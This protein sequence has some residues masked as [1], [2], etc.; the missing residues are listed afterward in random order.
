MSADLITIGLITG[1]TYALL[2]IGLVL[3]YRLQGTLNL[4][5]GEIGAF[6]GAAVAVLALRYGWPF[7]LALPVG[8][9]GGAVLAGL[10][11]IIVI[12][13]LRERSAVIVMVATL[14]VGQLAS[15]LRVSMPSVAPFDPFPTLVD[16][17]MT[18]GPIDLT[19]AE[20]GALLLAPTVALAVWWALSRT[21]AG[22][23]IRA[24]A[25]NPEATRLAGINA[26]AVSTIVWIVAGGLA[27]L[28]TVM[29]VPLRGGTVA[30]IATVG[31]GLLLRGFAAAA[32]GRFR[33]VPLTLAGGLALGVAEAL[34]LTWADDPGTANLIVF[35]IMLVGL[36]VLPRDT[37][38][39][40]ASGA[41]VLRPWADWPNTARV[42]MARYAP[43]VAMVVV[44]VAVPYLVTTAGDT[45]QL[46]RLAILVLV[47]ASASVLSGWSGQVSL[48]QYALAGV[49]AI[50]SARLVESGSTWEVSLLAGTAAAAAVAG[51]V[52]LPSS[53][54]RGS[55][56]A[57]GTLGF[58]VMAP[59]W[60]F[61]LDLTGDNLVFEVPRVDFGL[62]ELRPQRAYYFFVVVI[63][64]IVFALLAAVGRR[65][66]GRRWRAVNDNDRAASAYGISVWRVRVGAFAVSGAIAGLAGGLMGGLLVAYRRGEFAADASV[67]VVVMAVIGGLGS[68][69]GAVFGVLYV[70][71]LPAFFSD[72]GSL[73]LLVSGI[74][75]LVLLL[76]FPDG[77]ARL[78]QRGQRLLAGRPA[79]RAPTELDA[80]DIDDSD[81][82]TLSASIGELSTE[83]A[84]AQPAVGLE[85]SDI[86][87]VFGRLPAVDKVTLAVAPSSI[88][89]LIGPNG[90]GK[91][92]L[93]NVISGLQPATG[94]VVVG[95]TDVSSWSAARRA[96]IGVGRTFQDAR[97]FPTMTVREAVQ[98]AAATNERPNI[99]LDALL[100]R[101][102]RGAEHRI[103]QRADA[104]IELTG[105]GEYA[106]ALIAVLSTG[107]RRMVEIAGLIARAGDLLLFDEPTAGLA[108]REV[109]AFPSVLAAV[110]DHLT[111]TVVVVEH[112]VAMLATACDRL[113]CLEAGRVIA[114]GEPDEVRRDARVI[115][116]YLGPD[117]SAI[118]RSGTRSSN[119]DTRSQ[120]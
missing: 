85:V 22:A 75:L 80:V 119:T 69:A 102:F 62:F 18:I 118:G 116:S 101:A 48:A 115:E 43:A 67:E 10:T 105:L 95:G 13:R 120:P 63:V 93:L 100:P 65:A 7:L 23:V 31:P 79:R 84:R 35:V 20:I 12:K 2:G 64:A 90:A 117:A 74:G 61:R 25:A 109:E 56:L 41:G 83:A 44:I 38:Q 30:A 58:A 33:S 107:T 77:L 15:L 49:G 88:V 98:V 32:F 34:T 112:D 40:R 71:A 72:L 91:S 60:L 87:V 51:I 53:R 21:T 68:L 11:E 9:L 113:V 4:A 28:S 92:T 57:V 111:A 82:R 24:T 47:V 45:F 6:G 42:R 29:A 55:L 104:A 114:D 81:R 36:A 39:P 19:A 86:S 103:D 3:V 46:S 76:Y 14:G 27:V 17:R 50:T 110:R 89:G 73:Q 37:T 97:L 5:H 1:T 106:H 96:R 52:A 78:A 54:L 94:R 16:S 59:A 99:A 66:T 26:S 70:G 8:I 108:Q